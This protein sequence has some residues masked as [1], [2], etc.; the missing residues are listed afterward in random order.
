MEKK[1]LNFMTRNNEHSN[2]VSN[3]A[4]NIQGYLKQQK[5]YFHQIHI[6][7]V[8]PNLDLVWAGKQIGPILHYP[9]SSSNFAEISGNVG[10]EGM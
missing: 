1:I 5:C 6:F 8:R 3:A 9:T 10:S 4:K 2:L 7:S